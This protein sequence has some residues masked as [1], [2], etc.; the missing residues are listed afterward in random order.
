MLNDLLVELKV[1][2]LALYTGCHK[3]E[4]KGLVY[5]WIMDNKYA[6]L[7]THP[8]VYPVASFLESLHERIFYSLTTNR[9]F[10]KRIVRHWIGF[11]ET[12][13]RVKMAATTYC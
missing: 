6:Y 13:T 7:A 1:K 4:Y 2:K 9:G 10:T 12:R 5:L 3:V 8:L 11:M